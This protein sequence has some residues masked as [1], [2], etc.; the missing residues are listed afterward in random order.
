MGLV[1]R[2]LKGDIVAIG[3]VGYDGF[4]RNASSLSLFNQLQR[5]LRFVSLPDQYSFSAV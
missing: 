2:F 5:N 3:A 1:K 4:E